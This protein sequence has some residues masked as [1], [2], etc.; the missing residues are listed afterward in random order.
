RDRNK[1]D[2]PI[3]IN[4]WEQSKIPSSFRQLMKR[5][6]VGNDTFYNKIIKPL[7]NVGLIDIEEFEDSK[8]TGQKPMNIIV[9]KYPQ[10]N[11]SL[12]FAELKV[13]RNYDT[14]YSSTAKSF[15]IKGGRPK[16]EK[17]NH[18][19]TNAKKSVDNVDNHSS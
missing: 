12:S 7:W 14:D 19:S 18:N 2:K 9:Y 4:L 10:N 5:L 16:K 3:D 17:T 8:N 13:V 1:G 6:G 15:A 11:K